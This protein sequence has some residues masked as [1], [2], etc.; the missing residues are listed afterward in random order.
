MNPG[1]R[2]LENKKII[3][4]AERTTLGDRYS[5]YSNTYIPQPIYITYDFNRDIFELHSAR[6]QRIPAGGLSGHNTDGLIQLEEILPQNIQSP[7]GAIPRSFPSSQLSFYRNQ[8][9]RLYGISIVTPNANDMYAERFIAVRC[10]LTR[11]VFL[12]LGPLAIIY[13]DR[14]GNLIVIS[15]M[16]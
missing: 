3:A 4:V 8:L 1:D 15:L 10:G 7:I 6:R 12:R 11:Y 9:L 14:S 5:R 2:Y 13:K 16:D